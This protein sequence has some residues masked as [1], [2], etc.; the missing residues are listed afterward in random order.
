MGGVAL[1]C[2]YVFGGSI[3]VVP[4]QADFRNKAYH[5]ANLI[6]KKSLQIMYEI[7]ILMVTNGPSK[8]I[9]C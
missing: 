8:F 4:S 2:L 7:S 3:W 1:K 9:S 5:Y 6:S